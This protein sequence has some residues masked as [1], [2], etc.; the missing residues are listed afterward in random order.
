MDIPVLGWLFRSRSDKE[1]RN[2][3]IVLI[4]PTVLPTPEI[5]ALTAKA[6]KDKMPLVRSAE[7]EAQRIESKQMKQ[8]DREIK[9]FEQE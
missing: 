3:L 1:T 5:A 6:E 2:E 9:S 8:S 4:R 7:A